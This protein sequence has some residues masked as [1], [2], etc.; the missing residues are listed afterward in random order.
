MS[1]NDSLSENPSDFEY[2]PRN[3]DNG[4]TDITLDS[5][6]ESNDG[7]LTEEG[8][9]EY[10]RDART[11]RNKRILQKRLRLYLRRE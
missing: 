11:S 7:Y 1:D 5:G 2:V 3:T 10:I 4:S 6:I 8:I 9:E